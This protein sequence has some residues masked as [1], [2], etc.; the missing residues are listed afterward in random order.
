LEEKR[1]MILRTG[2]C[3]TAEYFRISSSIYNSLTQ[4]VLNGFCCS[5]DAF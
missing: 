1:D 5:A 4:C 3:S 2:Q